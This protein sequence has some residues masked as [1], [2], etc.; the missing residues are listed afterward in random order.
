MD[1][2]ASQIGHIPFDYKNKVWMDEKGLTYDIFDVSEDKMIDLVKPGEMLGYITSQAAAET[3]IAKELPVIAGGSDKGC[4]TLGTGCINEYTAAISLGTTATIQFS[5]KKYVEPTAFLPAYPAVNGG[6]NP[7]IEVFRGF[8]M[9]TWFKEQFA[10]DIVELAKQKGCVPEDLMDEWLNEI[11]IGACGLIIQPYWSPS[12]KRLEARGTM[13]GFTGEHTRKH[14]YR[15]IIEGIF[16]NLYEGMLS[17]EKRA[18]TR[19]TNLTISGGGASNDIICK[20]VADLF[21]IKVQRVQ[22]FETS[23]LGAAISAAVGAGVYADF[24][25]AIKGMVTYKSE[26]IPDTERHKK[27]L[28]VFRTKY[29]KL[30]KSRLKKF[31]LSYLN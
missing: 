8:W 23:S 6:Y 1:S 24:D 30:Y 25:Q 9:L 28:E 10:S 21:G 18:K 29:S 7:E 26:F 27:Y 11:E 19:I 16:Y 13:A 17:M 4:E 14:I 15:A 12:L 2:V 31:Y 3:G 22:T 5:T 20:M